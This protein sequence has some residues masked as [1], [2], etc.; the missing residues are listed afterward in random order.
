MYIHMYM[1]ICVYVHHIVSSY[2]NIKARCPFF[3]HLCVVVVLTVVHKRCVVLFLSPTTTNID[4]TLV[5]LRPL[6]TRYGSVPF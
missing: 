3:I 4:N 2:W 1:Y 5:Q 6:V